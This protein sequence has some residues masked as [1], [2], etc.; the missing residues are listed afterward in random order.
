LKG[1]NT[2][3]QFRHDIHDCFLPGKDTL[4]METQAKS[5]P[6]I[7]QSLWFERKW[8]SLYAAFQDGRIDDKRLREI[9]AH[10]LPKPDAGKWLWIG[11]DASNIARPDAVTSAD[12]RPFQNGGE[13]LY[14]LMVEF[15]PLLEELLSSFLPSCSMSLAWPGETFAELAPVLEWSP[16]GRTE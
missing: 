7:S 5:F 12:R 8:P 13:L 10:Y 4:M 11:M 6:K 9:F 14:F 16:T 3:R 15:P 1:I 2:L